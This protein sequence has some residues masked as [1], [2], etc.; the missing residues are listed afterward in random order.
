MPRQSFRFLRK[1]RPSAERRESEGVGKIR[2]IL[3]TNDD[4]IAADGL[5]RL[6]GAAAAFG[7]VWVIA[8]AGQRSAASHSITIREPVDV[9]PYDFPVEGVRAFTCSGTPAD[10]ARIGILHLMPDR[11]DMLLS[12]INFG[13]NMGADIQY[14]GT[15]GAAFEADRQGVPAIAVSEGMGDDH[16]LTDRELPG[17]L[18]M[19]MDRTLPAGQVYNVNFPLCPPEKYRGILENRA[20]SRESIY[21]DRYREEE[22]LPRGGIRLRVNGVFNDRSD[23]GTDFRAL[24][25]GYISISAIRNIQ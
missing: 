22:R 18:E 24:T 10:C 3:I 25:E 13:Y 20:V 1:E 9:Y 8:P 12:G 6:A 4:G 5:V 21:R 7:R 15:V 19:L 2:N 11:P 16:R 14:S 17:V 23:E